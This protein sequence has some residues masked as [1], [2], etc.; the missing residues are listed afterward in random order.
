M[1]AFLGNMES[2]LRMRLM[3]ILKTG[4]LDYG[5]RFSPEDY[6]RAVA[7]QADS[8]V[9]AEDVPGISHW[10]LLSDG[11]IFKTAYF[12]TEESFRK[13][14]YGNNNSAGLA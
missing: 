4:T 7:Q 6:M 14:N 9:I 2:G 8:I 11:G 5:E 10:W 12:G 1:L 3:N 13:W